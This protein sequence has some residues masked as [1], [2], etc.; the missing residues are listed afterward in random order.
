[1]ENQKK[2]SNKK[3]S[4]INAVSYCQECNLYL[5]NKCT[6]YHLEYLDTHHNYNLDKNNQNI[7]TGFCQEINHKN[8]LKYYCKN[9]NTLCCAACLCKIKDNTNGQHFNC[10]V[11]LIEKIKEEKKN[12]LKENLKY[13]EES[14]KNIEECLIKLKDIYD[15]INKSKEELKLK[16]SNTFTKLRNILNER[17]DKLLLELD[18]IYNDEYFKEDIIKKGDKL[19]KQIKINLEKGKI[20]DKDWDD[21]N[22]KLIDR[23]NDC[24]NIEN[25]IQNII[26][27]NKNIKKCNSKKTNIKFITED[28]KN[29]ILID[30]IKNFGEFINEDSNAFNFKFKPGANYDISNNGYV[31]SKNNGGDG[32]NC[33][34]V[35]DK[36]IPKDKISKWKIKIKKS[37]EK[38]KNYSDFHIG[39]G[40]KKMKGELY[41]DCWSI[42]QSGEKIS[43]RMKNNIPI[44][45]SNID[46]GL[47]EG[48]VV[49]I[50][51]DRTSGN[52]S[53]SVNGIS[54]GFASSA[55]PKNEELYPIVILYEQGLSVEIV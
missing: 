53:F 10:D 29:N 20:L 48:D 11:C 50:T 54:C 38:T 36:E 6:N 12:K 9:H 21:N 15:K 49:E 47:N 19:T 41:N 2:C 8:E 39:V 51:A 33:L 28:E 14:S 7:F 46:R 5:C 24:L 26:E 43:F 18:E 3:H 16:I 1:M 22:D 27:I 31:A 17:E 45:Q 44:N 35:G 40:E 42:Y 23:I 4:E 32:W 37:L 13:L 30:K 52:L 34:I 55:L 25:N